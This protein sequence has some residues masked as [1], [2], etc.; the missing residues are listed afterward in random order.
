MTDLPLLNIRLHLLTSNPPQRS[1]E[2]NSKISEHVFRTGYHFREVIVDEARK[3]VGD[4]VISNTTHGLI[5]PIPELQEEINK[6]ADGAIRDLFPRIPNTD[7]QRIIEHA[8][9]K[10]IKFHGEPTVGL[11]ADLPLARRVQLAV[12][13]H[14][15]HTHTRYDKL[16]RE[17]SWINARKAVEPVC[18]DV[19]VKW[20]GDEETGRDQMDEILR[21]VV[22]ITDSDE[23][24]EDSD[25]EDSPED[26]EEEGETSAE[27]A[28]LNLRDGPQ[29]RQPMTLEQASYVTGASHS[30]FVSSHTR[31]RVRPNEGLR[32]PQPRFKRYQAA[33]DEALS[34]RQNAAHEPNGQSIQGFEA[35]MRSAQTNDLPHYQELPR[36]QAS[37][38]VSRPSAPT[39]YLYRDAEHH[40]I[41]P[42]DHQVGP[43]QPE[44][45]HCFTTNIH[46]SV[47]TT[48]KRG[49]PLGQSF[50]ETMLQ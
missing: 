21:E 20:R 31:S 27:S 33:W 24:E 5:E 3:I 2:D 25:E 34:R 47:I 32:R 26:G 9:Q 16:L 11:Q 8:F 38:A 13:A 6:Q 36:T 15:R 14:I 49:N 37:S 48:H 35:S 23:E 17:T 41:I 46:R 28:A 4:T 50:V 43:I 44:M 40:H 19:L 45:Q 42:P 10:G 7:R 1:K 29:R 22:I 30:G 39:E 18:L 12:L